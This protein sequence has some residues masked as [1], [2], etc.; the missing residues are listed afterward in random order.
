M[1]IKIGVSVVCIILLCLVFNTYKNGNYLRKTEHGWKGIYITGTRM[2]L[3]NKENGTLNI[4]FTENKFSGK[5]DRLEVNDIIEKNKGS[6]LIGG[7][8][9]LDVVFFERMN[10]KGKQDSVIKKV[11][12]QLDK[13]YLLH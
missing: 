13:W 2:R 11:I 1:K 10:T 9:G 8:G 6:I 4:K 12:P 5:I 7:F 3:G